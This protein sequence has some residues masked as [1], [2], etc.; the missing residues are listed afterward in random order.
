MKRFYLLLMVSNVL[1]FVGLGATSQGAAERAANHWKLVWSDEF[2]GATIDSKKWTFDQGTGSAGWGN[3]ELECYTS[4]PSNAYV[5]DGMLHIRALKESYKGSRYTSA[6]L[7]TQGRFSQKYGRFKFRAKLPTGQ[8][9]WPAIWMMPAR[10]RYG[11]WAASGEIDIVE[12][13]GQEPNKVLGTLHYG[14]GWP[15]NTHA[16]KDYVLPKKGTIADFHVYAL[17]WEP[18]EIRWLVDGHCYQTQNFWWS[19][20]RRNRGR[21]VKPINAAQ[22]NPWPAP[23]NQPFYLLL[24]VAVGGNFVGSPNRTTKF[25]AEMVVDYVRVYERTGGYGKVKARGPGKLP[26]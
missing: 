9:I 8:G 26:Y 10:N 17:E 6:R 11:G 20:S 13:R 23:F 2:D 24:N 4:R 16:G 7:K 15:A 14:S 5:K 3:N 22:L 1:A 12:A 18:G 25:P 21:G 19:S